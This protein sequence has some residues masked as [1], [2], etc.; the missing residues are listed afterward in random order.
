MKYL[1]A[2]AIIAGGYYQFYLPKL[3]EESITDFMSEIKL[4]DMNNDYETMTEQFSELVLV[5]QSDRHSDVT[6][7]LEM[8]R[9]AL[10]KA[11]KQLKSPKLNL[12]DKSEIEKIE[13]LEEKALVTS[14]ITVWVT[15]EGRRIKR[16]SRE[17]LTIVIQKASLKVR[18][19]NSH[20]IK[21]KY[22]S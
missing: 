21:A 15:V 8:K 6:S 10:I 7:E 22:V 19:I 14:L 1:L 17:T 2:L 13:I 9:G 20:L 3:N 18:E 11:I 5:S 4:A 16:V 12:V